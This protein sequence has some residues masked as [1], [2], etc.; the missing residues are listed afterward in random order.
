MI[1]IFFFLTARSKPPT[2]TAPSIITTSI[3][4]EKEHNG[5]TPI[6]SVDQ[7]RERLR[8]ATRHQQ[9]Y[10]YIA[11]VCLCVR[12]YDR[13]SVLCHWL[14]CVYVC[15]FVCLCAC[16]CAIV[17]ECGRVRVRANVREGGGCEITELSV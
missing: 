14:V 8:T 4:E 15:R 17:C 2:P 6:D 1:F 5:H 11:R 13:C 7:L 3:D 9:R 16:V 12:L 10:A